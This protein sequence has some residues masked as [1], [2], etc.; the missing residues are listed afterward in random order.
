MNGGII[1]T[2]INTGQFLTK[3]LKQFMERWIQNNDDYLEN[4][5]HIAL[6]SSDMKENPE[7]IAQAIQLNLKNP[8]QVVP[9]QYEFELDFFSDP[10][11]PADYHDITLF[12]DWTPALI[13]PK[14]IALQVPSLIRKS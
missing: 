1:L 5:P 10:N 2:E 11:P 13:C 7:G 4:P 14:P 8:K 6:I 3:S 12:I 9:E